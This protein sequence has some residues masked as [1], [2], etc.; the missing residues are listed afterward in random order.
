MAT[1]L[2]NFAFP[3]EDEGFVKTRQSRFRAGLGFGRMW[4]RRAK[5][6][7][8]VCVSSGSPQAAKDRR[9]ILRTKFSAQQRKE[10]GNQNNK[11]LLSGT[12]RNALKKT[13]EQNS[14]RIG[15]RQRKRKNRNDKY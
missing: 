15:T 2:L 6:Y 8:R 9:S 1:V 4:A 5:R 14:Q 12:I 7:T 10:Q 11:N 13:Q 3:N